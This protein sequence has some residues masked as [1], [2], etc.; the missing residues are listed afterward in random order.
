M[1]SI[2]T[3]DHKYVRAIFITE[4]EKDLLSLLGHSSTQSRIHALS[5]SFFSTMSSK[6]KPD[7]TTI[8]EIA[9]LLGRLYYSVGDKNQDPDDMVKYQVKNED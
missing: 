7:S 3:K 5:K 4:K 8:R 1:R 2:K 9:E 6:P